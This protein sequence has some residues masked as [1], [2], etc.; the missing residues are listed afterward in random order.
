MQERQRKIGCIGKDIGRE[1]GEIGRKME[2][3]VADGNEPK[4][5][6]IQGKDAQGAAHPEA[7]EAKPQRGG[8][9][10]FF[11]QD[12][13]NEKSREHEKKL[14]ADPAEI[15]QTAVKAHDEQDGEGAN[16]V[17]AF[18]ISASGH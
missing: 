14:Y 13:C 7:F 17:E 4:V 5:A 2:K 18:D 16:P 6:V 1:E 8:I 10:F 9:E 15:R 11:P 12:A 3:Q